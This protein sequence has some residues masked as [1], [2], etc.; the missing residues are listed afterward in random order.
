MLKPERR[1]PLCR[2]HQLLSDSIAESFHSKIAITFKDFSLICL[3][4]ADPRDLNKASTPVFPGFYQH[5]NRC[6]GPHDLQIQ[7]E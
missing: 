5:R 4:R 7:C 1:E 6:G 3:I 2:E